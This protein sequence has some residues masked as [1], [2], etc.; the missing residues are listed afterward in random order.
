MRVL[1]NNNIYFD[2]QVT[3]SID[4]LFEAPLQ[5]SNSLIILHYDKNFGQNGQWDTVS[6]NG[7]IVQDRA[8]KLHSIEL[9]D[10]AITKYVIDHCPFVTDQGE[11][12]TT[13]YYGFNGQ[14]QI[15][16]DTPVYD[17]IIDTVIKPKSRK[18]LD[19]VQPIETSY[20]N[21]F[22]YKQDQVELEELDNILEKNAHLFSK[23][24]KI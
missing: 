4:V 19:L 3:D 1:L 21:L 8:I 11:S 12:I 7:V 15:N 5:Q 17:W 2:N 13:S 24:P 16:F 18:V 22:D 6:N 23:S 10:V 20:D 14:V 9:D